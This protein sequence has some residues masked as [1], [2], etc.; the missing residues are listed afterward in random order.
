MRRLQVRSVL[1]VDVGAEDLAKDI[2][3]ALRP[4]ILSPPSHRSK[5]A[6]R[7]EGGVLVIDLESPDLSSFRAAFNSYS[8]LIYA[9]LSTLQLLG[10]V[11]ND[12]K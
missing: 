6:L 10:A 1:R 12:S 5:V 4:E 11:R 9:V 8:R 7:L 2:Y 3:R